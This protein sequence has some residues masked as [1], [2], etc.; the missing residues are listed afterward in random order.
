MEY[1]KETCPNLVSE[2]LHCLLCGSSNL[3]LIESLSEN[4]IKDLWKS[5]GIYF[6]R[7]LFR[8]SRASVLVS[9]MGCISCGFRFF[10]PSLAGTEYFYEKLAGTSDSYYSDQRPEYA[11]TITFAKKHRLEKVLDV[12]CGTGLFLDLAKNHGLFTAGSEMNPVAAEASRRKMHLMLDGPI[13]SWDKRYHAHFDLVCLFQVLEH[14]PNPV[15]FLAE[16]SPF[17]RPSGFFSIAVPNRLGGLRL[18]PFEPSNWPPHHISHWSV[19][20]LQQ[21]ADRAGFTC[22]RVGADLLQASELFL[23]LKNRIIQ[24]KTLGQKTYLN[25]FFINAVCF[26]YRYL[27]AKTF[28]PLRGHSIFAFFK[29]P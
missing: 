24:K 5:S 12:G 7:P 17:L 11:R 14:L 4:Q 16:L 28:L 20:D 18:L 3:E 21:L 8:D 25:L 19:F 26:L 10:D 29:K 23:F 15:S 13:Q 22:F 2:R 1:L 9:L 27:K 6:E